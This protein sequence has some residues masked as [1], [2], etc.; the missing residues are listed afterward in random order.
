MAKDAISPLRVLVIDDQR[1]VTTIIGHWLGRN[2][3]VVHTVN[4]SRGALQ[5]L[6]EFRP[7]V[8]ILD[9]AMPHLDGY[10]IARRI[11]REPGFDGTPIVACTTLQSGHHYVQAR[12]AGITHHIAKPCD[13]PSL[14]ALVTGFDTPRG[15]SE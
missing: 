14:E 13:L 4:D 6:C 2:G 12:A 1:S 8:V 15:Q 5:A 7:H 9:I 3:H 11:R 10:E